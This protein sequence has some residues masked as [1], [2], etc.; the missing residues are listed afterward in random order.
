MSKCKRCN[1]SL[2]IA[3]ESGMGK[4]CQMKANRAAASDE[5]S[6]RVEPLFLRRQAR[7]SYLVFTSPRMRVVVSETSDGRFAH[8]DCGTN[9]FCPHIAAVAAYD[10]SVFPLDPAA[11]VNR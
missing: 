6:V 9:C 5:K 4:I 10:R 1:R 11:E 3:N 2:K 7:R 8:C